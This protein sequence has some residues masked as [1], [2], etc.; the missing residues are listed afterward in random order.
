MWNKRLL[1]ISR[2]K[3]ILFYWN[4]FKINLARVWLVTENRLYLFSI[5]TLFGCCILYSIPKVLGTVLLYSFPLSLIFSDPLFRLSWRPKRRTITGVWS[6][7]SASRTT[8]AYRCLG[9]R[10]LH[11][12][13][14]P[15]PL[16]QSTRNGRYWLWSSRDP[17]ICV[18][19]RPIL[20]DSPPIWVPTLS[21]PP[22]STGS[23][24]V[25]VPS[26]SFET[27]LG[28]MF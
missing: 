6:D 17:P 19:F 26:F 22:S 4:H 11:R 10:C 16:I 14:S 7:K 2:N 20:L 24:E 12:V 23:N 8:L 25:L 5:I 9:R 18:P 1:E 3:G 27:D 15:A 13:P 21:L 28:F